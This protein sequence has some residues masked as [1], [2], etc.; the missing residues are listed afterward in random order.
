MTYIVKNSAQSVT[1]TVNDNT[2][3]TNGTSLTLIGKNYS[4]YGLALTKTF[5][6]F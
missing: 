1:Y 4:G 3:N 6:I 5:C 2:E